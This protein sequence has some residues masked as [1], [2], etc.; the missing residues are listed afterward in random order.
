MTDPHHPPHHSDPLDPLDELASAHLDGATSPDEAA[1]V[2]TDPELAARVE[3]LAGA[4]EA[5]RA[6]VDE[7]VDVARR[8]AA[9]AA[10]LS[11]Y[12]EAEDAAGAP[13]VAVPLVRPHRSRP[14]TRTLQ[15][16]GIAAAVVALALTVPLLD[17]L[18]SDDRDDTAS[19]SFDVTAS[20]VTPSLESG[21]GAGG[22]AADSASGLSGFD[23][24]TAPD[25]GAFADLDALRGEVR[26]Q[27]AGQK[28]SSTTAPSPGTA[29][30]GG[31][32]APERNQTCAPA[33]TG[34]VVYLA[35]ATLDGQPVTV[36]VRDDPAG[37]RTLVVLDAACATLS[38]APL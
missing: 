25:L 17:R 27:V 4:R 6:T 5:L 14:R 20:S 2:A 31:E 1:Q 35:R 3:R 33:S 29:A 23:A 24:A 37:Q 11:A 16:I 38:E 21:G 26:A 34:T 18:G 12:G 9:I 7:P 15:L 8:D 28:A 13:A 22:G 30:V 36:V 10:A 32:S 19:S